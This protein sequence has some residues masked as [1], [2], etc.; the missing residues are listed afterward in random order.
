VIIGI[1]PP[2]PAILTVSAVAAEAVAAI[3]MTTNALIVCFI[4]PPKI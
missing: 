3:A 1:I 2:E 4:T